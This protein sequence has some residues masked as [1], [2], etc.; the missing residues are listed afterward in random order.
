MSA[1]RAGGTFGSLQWPFGRG[2]LPVP[3][4]TIDV[5]L[6]VEAPM[7]TSR[8]EIAGVTPAGD[9]LVALAA[10]SIDV[11]R[12]IDAALL[13]FGTRSLVA[14]SEVVDLLLDLRLT[15]EG[16]ADLPVYALAAPTAT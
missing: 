15:A 11:R 9:G 12:A 14:G 8:G 4:P 5:A 3:M 13:R 10:D 6:D 7:D 16:G 2:V 1:T